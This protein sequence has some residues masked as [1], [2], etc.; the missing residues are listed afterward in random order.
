MKGNSLSENTANELLDVPDVERVVKRLSGHIASGG[1]V[2]LL[3]LGMK[4]RF[5]KLVDSSCVVVMK[6]GH[7]DVGHVLWVDSQ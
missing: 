6:V 4:G 5:G 3:V 1:E 2:H 7:D